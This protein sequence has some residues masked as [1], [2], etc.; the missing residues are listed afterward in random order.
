MISGCRQAADIVR[1]SRGVVVVE[2]DEKGT[3]FRDPFQKSGGL[4][5]HL[6]S[7]HFKY[8]HGA[9]ELPN[10]RYMFVA[11]AK[12]E[13]QQLVPAVSYDLWRSPSFNWVSP[14]FMD[15]ESK[16]WRYYGVIGRHVVTMELPAA[17]LE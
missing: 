11:H 17:L 3:Y 1:F 14:P 10:G 6:A 13:Q 4:D 9:T 2:A 12:H 5:I 15:P 8:V 16:R 7:T